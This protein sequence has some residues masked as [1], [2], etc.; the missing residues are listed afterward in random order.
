MRL[1]SLKK[2]N[3]RSIWERFGKQIFTFLVY[4]SIFHLTLNSV[5]KVTTIICLFSK[6][7][8]VLVKNAGDFSSFR[9]LGILHEVPPISKICYQQS[10]LNS[11]MSRFGFFKMLKGSIMTNTNHSVLFTEP[12]QV[13]TILINMTEE[14][15][16]PDQ[17]K[18]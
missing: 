1:D 6:W 14:C 2:N 12:P 11:V 15:L 8:D 18:R 16:S 5:L 9:L 10:K 7:K 17:E 3:I 13:R 4:M